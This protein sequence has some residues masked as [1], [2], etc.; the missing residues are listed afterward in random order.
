MFEDLNLANAKTKNLMNALNAVGAGPS[1]LLVADGASSDVIRASNNIPRLKAIP[2]QSLNAIDILDF[3][4][5]VMT[6]A[7]VRNA[8]VI[9]GGRFQQEHMR[10]GHQRF[11][12]H[13][14]CDRER[15]FGRVNVVERPVGQRKFH[16][17]YWE[18]RARET[19]PRRLSRA[20]DG[21]LTGREFS[22]R[23]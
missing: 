4:S 2:S 16:I 11:C 3:Q 15:H 6:E 10:S 13:R 5:I 23:H 20:R 7:A 21:G 19:N 12:R 22:G 14:A 8:E 1:I 17:H 9:W 18:S